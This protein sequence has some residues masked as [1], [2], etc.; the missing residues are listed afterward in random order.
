MQLLTRSIAVLAALLFGAGATQAAVQFG[1]D[2]FSFAPGGGYGVD[3][4]S[5]AEN[6]GTLLDVAFSPM[7]APLA[8]TLAAGESATFAV[9]SVEL[10]ETDAGAGGNAGIRNGENDALDVTASIALL[11]PFASMQTVSAAGSATLGLI[12]DAQPDYRLDWAPLVVGFGDGGAFSIS[13]GDLTFNERGALTQY[14]T[15]TLLSEPQSV[16]EPGSLAL[17]GALLLGLGLHGGRRRARA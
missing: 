7:P 11:A 12:G 2:G 8:F 10:R 9:G 16:P 15:I 14:A 13:L 4:G 5:N 6:G 1:L 17:A 3:S